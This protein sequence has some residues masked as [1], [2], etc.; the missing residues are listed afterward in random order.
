MNLFNIYFDAFKTVWTF[1]FSV[2]TASRK[3]ATI[4]ALKA[5]ILP[6]GELEHRLFKINLRVSDTFFLRCV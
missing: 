3:C 2:A 4:W 1:S 6:S 5:Y